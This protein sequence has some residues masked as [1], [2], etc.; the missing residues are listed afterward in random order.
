MAFPAVL[1][2]EWIKV[3]SLPSLM[4]SLLTV[5]VATAGLSLLICGALGR[6][7][8]GSTDFDPV[9]FSYYGLNFGQLA[10]IVFGVIAMGGEYKNAGIRVSLAAVPDRTL[11]YGAKLAMVGG[12]VFAVG[13]VASLISFLGGQALMDQGFGRGIADPGAPRAVVGCAVYLA[14]VGVLAAGVAAVLRS[15]TG[16]LSVLVPLF[17]IL[18]FVVGDMAQG[19]GAA[20]FLPDRAGQQILLQHP[21]GTLGPWSGMAVLV[22]WTM[23]AT[24][25]GWWTLRRRDA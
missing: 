8:P 6:P 15:V 10:A 25:A 5:P 17:L 19:G 2:T 23:V 16:A 22:A 9:L 3:R 12:C 11:F 18:P 24:G 7:Q 20:D 4:G 21:A 1:H 13:L 14:L